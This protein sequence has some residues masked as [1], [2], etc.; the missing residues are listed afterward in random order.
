MQIGYTSLTSRTLSPAAFGFYAC[1]QALSALVGYISFTTLGSAVLRHPLESSGGLTGLG[2]TLASISGAAA[3]GLTY[4]VAPLWAYLWHLNGATSMVRLMALAVGLSPIATVSVALVRRKL[5]FRQAA[6]AELLGSLLGFATGGIVVLLYHSPDGLIWSRVATLAG[7]ILLTLPRQRL[8]SERQTRRASARTLLGFA[9]RVG[10]QN[11]IYYFIYNL[12]AFVISRVIGASALGIYSRANILVSLPLTQMAQTLAKVLYPIWGRIADI[13]A[14]KKAVTDSLVATS[15]I[16]C[17]S[18]GALFGLA[19]PVTRV[20]LGQHFLDAVPLIRIL[21]LFGMLNLQFTIGGSLQ[22]AMNWMRDVWALQ[23]IK[24]MSFAPLPLVFVIPSLPFCAACLTLTQLTGHAVQ[25]KQLARRQVLDTTAIRKA[26]KRHFFISAIFVAGFL[27][28]TQNAL[29]LELQIAASACWSV[30]SAALL[31]RYWE[32][33]P[34]MQV[35]E[36]R[37]VLRFARWT[38]RSSVARTLRAGR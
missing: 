10:T 24:L 29:S 31:V 1:A 17:L 36:A 7:L 25:L 18:F 13:Q 14:T 6:L 34:G 4:L 27:F 30:A 3:G 37:Q 19:E 28:A 38:E 21:A 26:Y 22:E 33:V 5:R 15:M 32:E 2:L 23:L 20:L 8:K 11:G 16:G 12:P 9:S 35:L